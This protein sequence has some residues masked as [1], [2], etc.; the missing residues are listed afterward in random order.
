MFQHRNMHFSELVS[1]VMEPV[2][3]MMEGGMEI[4]STEDMI[5]KINRRNED[6]IK[7]W[8]NGSSEEED[9][10][11]GKGGEELIIT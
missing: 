10:L 4:I 9:D 7:K 2:A 11:G 8:K 1:N 3:N 5:S 6:K